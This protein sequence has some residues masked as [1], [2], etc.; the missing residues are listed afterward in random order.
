MQFASGDLF[1]RNDLRAPVIAFFFAV[2]A[3]YFLPSIFAALVNS[4]HQGVIF[5]LN[6]LL[7][8]TLVGWV[9]AAFMAERWQ[10]PRD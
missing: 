4:R 10:Q 1:P 5:L 2:L 3:V 7:G 9:I 8:W 6:L